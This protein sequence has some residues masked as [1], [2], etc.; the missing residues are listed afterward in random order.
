MIPSIQ[1]KACQ[2]KALDILLR[3]QRQ[4]VTDTCCA[5]GWKPGDPIPGGVGARS[6]DIQ[7]VKGAELDRQ[8]P[9]PDGRPEL[10]MFELILNPEWEDAEEE[11]S[12]EEEEE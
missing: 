6:A 11:F 8:E 3:P 7:D 10:P 9:A 5:L 12:D 4:S 1:R 2:C